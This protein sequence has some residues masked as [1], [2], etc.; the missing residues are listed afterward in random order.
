MRRQKRR[1]LPNV[2]LTSGGQELCISPVAKM[3]YKLRG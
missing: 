2:M 3:L 1:M